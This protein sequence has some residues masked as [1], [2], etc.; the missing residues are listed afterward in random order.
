LSVFPLRASGVGAVDESEA[1]H[2]K[3]EIESSKMTRS[4]NIAVGESRKGL[5]ETLALFTGGLKILRFFSFP[6]FLKLW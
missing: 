5:M 6:F 2:R 4:L 3:K 1:I